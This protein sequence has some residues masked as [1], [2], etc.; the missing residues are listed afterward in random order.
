MS[1]MSDKPTSVAMRK[2]RR[3]F[4]PPV[5]PRSPCFKDSAG[6]PEAEES[7]GT[8][9]NKMP[10]TIEMPRLNAST[11]PLR[12]ISLKFWRPGGAIAMSNGI[13]Q[14]ASTTPTA[15]PISANSTLS[16]SSCRINR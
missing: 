13:A 14:E 7:A 5:L 3:R 4:P 12:P 9:P 10:V 6:L 8:S 15:P 11:W 2:A 1:K 16:V